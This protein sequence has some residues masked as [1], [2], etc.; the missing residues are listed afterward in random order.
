MDPREATIIVG[1]ALAIAKTMYGLAKN[2]IVQ[3]PS[4]IFKVTKLEKKRFSVVYADKTIQTE[5]KTLFE[6]INMGHWERRI[7]KDRGID[8]AL[9]PENKTFKSQTA[10]EKRMKKNIAS[11]KKLFEFAEKHGM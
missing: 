4:K 8:M 9:W 7:F 3:N 5:I 10:A 11:L 2:G 1:R 6:E